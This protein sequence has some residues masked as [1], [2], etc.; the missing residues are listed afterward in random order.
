MSILMVNYEY[1]PV[2]GGASNASFFQARALHR[3][4]QEVVVLT[5]GYRNKVGY[6]REDGVHVYRLRTLRTAPDHATMVEMASYLAA[7]LVAAPGIARRH[8]VDKAI[9]FFTLPCGPIG[10]VLKR[11]LNIP[12]V[13]SLRGGDVPNFIPEL[14][15]V[16]RLLAPI[17][18]GVFRQATRVVAISHGLAEL[19]RQTD[20]FPV[21]VIHNGID[22]DFFRPR[23]EPKELHRE[24][25]PLLFVGR[26]HSQKNIF[27]LLDRVAELARSVPHRLVLHLVGDGPQRSELQDYAA[28]LGINRQIIWHGWLGKEQLRSLYQL[29]GCLVMPSLNEAFPNTILEAMACGLP[30]VGS[31]VRGINEMVKT[32]ENGYL[33][34]LNYPAEF[35]L[36]MQQLVENPELARRL[37]KAARQSVQKYS[38]GQVADEYLKLFG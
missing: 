34:D 32:A 14:D 36:A 7:G 38:W 25:F 19:S 15:P 30:V 24:P 33:A 3:L 23:K 11:R 20:P 8:R 13:V 18:R 28:K 16:H 22:L 17:R 21:W 2:G 4:G 10:Y 27:F 29:A 35:T 6:A 31:Q 9:V 26:F 5:S 1:P 37:G 12:Y